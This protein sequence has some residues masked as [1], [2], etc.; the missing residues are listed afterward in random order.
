M[1]PSIASILA[2]TGSIA[3]CQQLP[4]TYGSS[5]QMQQAA[6]T[7]QAAPASTHKAAPNPAEFDKQ[8]AQVQEN[9]KMMQ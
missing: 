5:S 4:P 3:G 9:L 7:S 6:P 2:L 8:M 1:K